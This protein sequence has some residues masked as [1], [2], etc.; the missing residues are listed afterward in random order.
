MRA[1]PYDRED[2]RVIPIDHS[3][4]LPE[5]KKSYYLLLVKCFDD[6]EI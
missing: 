2:I 3:G 4:T 5:S 1:N 6:Q